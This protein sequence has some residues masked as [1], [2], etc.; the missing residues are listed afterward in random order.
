M[1]KGDFLDTFLLYTF[2]KGDGRKKYISVKFVLPV[3]RT[4]SHKIT[5]S[6]SK[7]LSHCCIPLV[8][9]IKTT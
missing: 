2:Y 1:C 7:K 8:S 3:L 9:N 6:R 4:F 5:V